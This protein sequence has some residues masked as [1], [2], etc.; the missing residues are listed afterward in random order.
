M[1]TQCIIFI[2]GTSLGNFA[3]KLIFN[4]PR[5][6]SW[7]R[8]PS[9]CSNCKKP[10]NRLA[11]LPI[12]G[13]IL[14]KGHCSQCPPPTTW[15]HVW[16]EIIMGIGITAL[17]IIHGPN[18]I[19]LKLTLFHFFTICIFFTDLDTT[20]I[21]DS[22]SYPLLISGLV[23]STFTN[24]LT[25]SLLGSIIGGSIFI[26]LWAI[27]RL[28]YKQDAMGIGDI[29]LIIAIGSFWGWQHIILT[30]YTS[31]IIG[32]L[33]SIYLIIFKKRSRKEFIP[34][35]PMIISAANLMIVYD[36][37]LWIYLTTF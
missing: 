6:I 37:P 28:I 3:N 14:Q 35:G 17:Y 4:L 33:I 34:F 26:T 18:L 20:L 11:H 10:L 12:V 7:T 21:P 24:T 23:L 36:T 25:Q 32:S 29:K 8:H 13:F 22:L 16:I 5:R 15:R 9:Q 30:T 31:F 2:L 1:L 19:F 27:S